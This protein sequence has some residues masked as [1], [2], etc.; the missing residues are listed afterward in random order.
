MAFHVLF[1]S[2][3]KYKIQNVKRSGPKFLGF[4]I[5]F[6]PISGP[7]AVPVDSGQP[8]QSGEEGG[9]KT[10]TARGAGTNNCP[11]GSRQIGKIGNHKKKINLIS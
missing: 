11:A 1:F 6:F 3:N 8:Q 2:T 7:G 9:S 4:N 10:L 5:I